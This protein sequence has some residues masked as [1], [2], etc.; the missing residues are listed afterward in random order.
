MD[1]ENPT[2]LSAADLPTRRRRNPGTT[3]KP[4]ESSTYA[5]MEFK[6]TSL[7]DRYEES[8]EDPESG[9]DETIETI[10]EQEIYGMSL[11]RHRGLT[12]LLKYQRPH[13]HH[14]GS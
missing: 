14:L 8:E 2:I 6:S 4:N 11:F 7:V 10:D 9:D 5:L 13:I 12:H 3:A 1:N